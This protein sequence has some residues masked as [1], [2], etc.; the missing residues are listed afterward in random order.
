MSEKNIR[1]AMN[2][3]THGVYVIGTHADGKYNLMTAAWLSQVSGR[4]PMLMAAVSKSHYTAELLK[5]SSRFSVSVLTKDQRETALKCGSV[6]GRKKDKLAEVDV[7][8]TEE[9]LP[10]IKGAASC[11]ICEVTSVTESS[12][13]CIF[14]AEAVSGQVFSGEALLYREKDFF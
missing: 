4:P 1:S 11:I 2:T 3:M 9:G 14:I 8:F 13:H 7:E 6:S 12:D 5:A 10:F